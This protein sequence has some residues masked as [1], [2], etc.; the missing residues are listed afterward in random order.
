MGDVPIEVYSKTLERCKIV[1][2]EKIEKVY[3]EYQ[4]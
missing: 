4:V 2:L 1:V 3:R